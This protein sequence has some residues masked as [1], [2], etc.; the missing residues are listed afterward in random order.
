MPSGPAGIRQ[1]AVLDAGSKAVLTEKFAG[2]Q[3]K[4][5]LLRTSK[6]FNL[7]SELCCPFVFV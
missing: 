5:A 4:E 1:E 6:V 2:E 3:S 7:K